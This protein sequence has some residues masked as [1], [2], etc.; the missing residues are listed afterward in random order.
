MI[1]K[2]LHP[3]DIENHIK[4]YKK[5]I[6]RY[7]LDEEKKAEE[8]AAFLTEHHRK[9]VTPKEFSEMFNMSEQEAKLFL[10]FIEVGLN[11]KKKHIDKR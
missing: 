5:I 7:S 6:K 8:I 11:F 10:S 3:M 2:I 9:K 1:T 4:E